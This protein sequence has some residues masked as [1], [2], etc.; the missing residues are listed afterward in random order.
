M[1]PYLAIRKSTQ[2]RRA[3]S[4]VVGAFIFVVLLLA[5]LGVFVS[6]MQ[7]Q[8]N[9]LE[10]QLEIS[11]KGVDK[12]REEFS[13]S[14][15]Y[16]NSNNNRLYVNVTNDGSTHAEIVDLFIVNKSLTTQDVKRYDISH[17]DAFVPL[18]STIDILKNQPLY[19]NTG[20]YDVKVV[21]AL[22][23]MKTSEMTV[24]TGGGSSD[25]TVSV[26]TVPPDI[27][28]G[29][30]VTL[31]MHVYNRGT[32]TLNNVQPNG[33]PT[34]LP[35]D[36]VSDFALNTP[37]SIGQLNPDEDVLFTW[38]Y[39]ILG[40][41]G[42]IVNFTASAT[43]NTVT[44]ATDTA[45]VEISAPFVNERAPEDV[46][47]K[48]EIFVAFPNPFG[49][50]D[51]NDFGYLAVILVNP[52]NST[53]TVNQV[54]LQIISKE[55]DEIIKNN[56][57]TAVK[58][59]SGWASQKN[60]VYWS[61]INNPV[62]IPK[63]SAEEFIVKAET[64]NTGKDNPINTIS[65]NAYTSWGQFGKTDHSLGVYKDKTALANVYQSSSGAGLDQKYVIPGLI[66]NTANT[67][68]ITIENVGKEVIESN[69]HMLINIPPG[70]SNIQNGT[71][72]PNF[73]PQTMLTF[74][75]GSHQIP[76]RLDTN[77]VEDEK[78][79][80][81]FSAIS[82]DI[83]E[84]R[85]YLFGIFA[86]GVATKSGGGGEKAIVGPVAETVVQ[87]CPSSGC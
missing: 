18:S 41:S 39:K 60:V 49:D 44:S 1:L 14:A 52:T 51:N 24:T 79:T 6:W 85:M 23:T 16:D 86:N 4:T 12:L 36:S 17:S 46:F 29:K 2:K 22:G 19:M 32:V 66:S 26:F 58:P 45:E 38:D 69:S 61:D 76:V 3:V 33:D 47:A 59:T 28:S 50:A 57:E 83:D 87:V 10:T 35:S 65:A 13:I 74:D 37:S 67:Y 48:P 70:F 20:T 42:G 8:S 21:S 30:N 75:D 82:P 11:K 81:S 9:L 5:A 62:T 80:Y 55:N 15:S 68:Y 77:L 7:L 27:A 54:S 73:S 34:V 64:G 40:T 63:Y 25:I 84:T 72:S 43:S 71:S 78:R 56:Q 53:M 31:A